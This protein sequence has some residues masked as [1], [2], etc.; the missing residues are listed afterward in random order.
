MR[1]R[2]WREELRMLSQV[3]LNQLTLLQRKKAASSGPAVGEKGRRK[4]PPARAVCKYWAARSL[5]IVDKAVDVPVTMLHM[6]QQS[7][8]LIQF[9]DRVLD[10]PV[11][12][13][14]QVRMVPNCAENGGLHKC[15][16]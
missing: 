16:A 7:V 2:I 6:F 10:I 4:P 9:I 14:R 13:Q 8:P 1:R 11:V 5:E 15:S 12:P 3:H